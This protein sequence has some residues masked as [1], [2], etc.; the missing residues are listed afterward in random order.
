MP[1][2]NCAASTA[3]RKRIKSALER[4]AID[5]YAPGMDVK[6]LSGREEEYRLRVLVTVIDVGHRRNVHR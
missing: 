2:A 5:P 3:R 4:L 1:N 6:K